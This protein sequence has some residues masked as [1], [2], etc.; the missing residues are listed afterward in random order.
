MLF[1]GHIVVLVY[2]LERDDSVGLIE[3]DQPDA[4]SFI[5]LDSP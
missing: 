2:I 3:V 1:F 5:F 4:S